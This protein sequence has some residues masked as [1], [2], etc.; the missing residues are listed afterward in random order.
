V[1]RER[2][3]QKEGILKFVFY[4]PEYSE[5]AGGIAAQYVLAAK[6]AQMGH[7][8]S[9]WPYEKPKSFLSLD[10]CTMVLR[11]FL[12]LRWRKLW[13]TLTW[14][15]GNPPPFGLTYA[16]KSFNLADCVV[17]YTETVAG[18]PLRAENVVRWVLYHPAAF[19]KRK[20][21][22]ESNAIFF[23][24]DFA[25][26]ND[27]TL[28][29]RNLLRLGLF[30]RSIYTERNETRHGNAVL[31]RKGRRL[32]PKIPLANGVLIDGMNHSD[33]AKIFA[34]K[35]YLLSYDPCTAY[36]Q[37]AALSGC[38]PVVVPPPDMTFNDWIAYGGAPHGVA[39][40][41]EDIPRAQF[42]LSTL[43]DEIARD[44][45]VEHELIENFVR[46]CERFFI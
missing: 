11:R 30:F 7:R 35:K 45:R 13:R 27:L 32:W 16:K 37:Y 41:L 23:H 17:V 12:T 9:I 43:F 15:R 42:T 26:G 18:N 29:E 36:L 8:V 46:S 14:Y 19:S 34:S 6:L 10:F 28:R 33:V 38:I 4:A 5:D 40:G 20:I 31:I 22:Y 39:F 44:E 25:F 1:S 2:G 24:W 21:R 3:H